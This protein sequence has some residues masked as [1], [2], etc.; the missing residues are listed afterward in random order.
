MMLRRVLA[1]AL[2]LAFVAVASQQ[3]TA[4]S[5]EARTA[6]LSGRYDEAIRTWEGL[7]R[8]GNA[9]PE[10][11]RGLLTA[12][13]RLGQY[14]RAIEVG[15]EYVV[16]EPATA[17]EVLNRLGEALYVTG[18][19][20]GA[21]RSFMD[22]MNAGAA[23]ELQARLNLAIAEFDGGARRQA[24]ARFETFIDVYND[25]QATSAA[26]LMAVARACTYLGIEDPQLFH[27]AVRAFDRAIEAAPGDPEP[28]LRLGE[29]FLDKY[30]AAE[31]AGLIGE[32]LRLDDRWARA[33]VAE[34]RRLQFEGSPEALARTERALETNPNYVPAW[35]Q[36]GTMLLATGGRDEATRDARQALEVNPGSVDALALLA[37]AQY[38]DGDQ[39]AYSRTV[40]RALARN[41]RSGDLYET[42]AEQAAQNRLYAEAVTLSLQAVE[43]DSVSWESWGTLGLNQLRIGEIDAGRESLQR[44][45]EGDPFNV[46]YKNTLD[47]LDTFVDYRTVDTENF[48]LFMRADRAE[49]M[50]PYLGEVAEDAWQTLTAKYGYAPPAPVRVEVFERHADFS[51]RTVGLAGL[52]ALGVAFG[53]VIAVDAPGVSGMGEFNWGSTLW[54]EIAHVVAMGLSGSR[55]PRWFTEGLSVYEEH[56]ARPGWGE[57]VDPGFLLAYA[58]GDML[59]VSRMND[60]FFRPRY[61]QHIGHSYVQGSLVFEFLEEEFG[62]EVVPRLLR[63]YARGASDAEAFATVLEWEMPHLDER[64]DHY[65]RTRFAGPLGALQAHLERGAGEEHGSTGAARELGEILALADADSED[66]VAHLQAGAE[67]AKAGRL[68]EA[69]PYL[70]RAKRLFPGHAGQDSP[71]LFLARAYAARGDTAAAIDELTTFVSLTDKNL[72]ARLWLARL[73]E[74]SGSPAAAAAAL[75]T[76]FYIDLDLPDELARAARL[77]ERADNWPAVVRARQALLGLDPVDR[78]AAYYDLARAHLGAGDASA[79]RRAVLFALEIAP[80][81]EAAQELLLELRSRRSET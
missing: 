24:M 2:V 64:F 61:P 23:D 39:A 27:D 21:T 67:L 12:Y 74:E 65:V 69:E 75:E 30:D 45:F 8:Q 55:V 50:A 10:D 44:A 22:A 28:R 32:A 25:G 36:R 3:A 63:E 77:H 5:A 20:E 59:P 58:R 33:H 66:F 41:P 78:A 31:A 6:L 4:Q 53:P 51:V 68:E 76:A 79:A 11:M 52:G 43:A 54:H 81:Y 40:E 46:W 80:S 47:L 17:G 37:A 1:S 18:D 16:T 9:S 19:V 42:V 70:R 13:Q 49:L 71:Y 72:E 73:L 48:E 14:E 60:G 62:F 26:D 7:Y 38:L 29:L 15:R 56:R 35:I 57:H 34:A